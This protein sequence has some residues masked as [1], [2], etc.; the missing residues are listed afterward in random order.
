MTTTAPQSTGLS[1]SRRIAFAAINLPLIAVLLS[2]AVYLAPY[3]A[4]QMGVS[5]AVV[6]G[7]FGL[8]RLLDVPFDPLLGMSTAPARPSAATGC[9]SARAPVRCWRS[10]CCSTPPRA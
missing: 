1:L 7:A 8:V 3:M 9:G 10:T 4:T 2:I 5:L 6:G